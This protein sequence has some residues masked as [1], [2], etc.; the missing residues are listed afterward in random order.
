MAQY[1]FGRAVHCHEHSPFQTA[2]LL[3][4]FIRAPLGP[5]CGGAKVPAYL[6][7]SM[8]LPAYRCMVTGCTVVSI[9]LRICDVP[10]GEMPK[11]KIVKA[12]VMIA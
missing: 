8:Y 9:C 3:V 4:L 11:A 2:Y 6:P 12:S 10:S 5:R 1:E 7:R